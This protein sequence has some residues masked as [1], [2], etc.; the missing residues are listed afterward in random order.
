MMDLLQRVE[1]L[2]ALRFAI[3]KDGQAVCVTTPYLD[4][5]NDYIEVYVFGNVGGEQNFL[6]TDDGEISRDARDHLITQ[7][8]LRDCSNSRV[9]LNKNGDMQMFSDI[10]S[11]GRDIHLFGFAL[12]IVSTLIGQA[13][14]KRFA[15]E[16][17]IM[18]ENGWTSN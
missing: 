15:E 2:A 4:R 5:H 18:K 6:I 3:S 16:L 17:L 12:R 14:S 8:A 7:V 1:Q 10:Q 11:L 9:H 13:D